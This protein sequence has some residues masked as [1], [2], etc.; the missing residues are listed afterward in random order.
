M[1]NDSEDGNKLLK[2][3]DGCRTF[4]TYELMTHSYNRLYPQPTIYTST[5]S[6]PLATPIPTSSDPPS[7]P[8]DY[9]NQNYTNQETNDHSDNHNSSNVDDN[10]S[11]LKPY[12]R[13]K[14]KRSH[15]S[16][17]ALPLYPWYD[18]IAVEHLTS[19]GPLCPTPAPKAEI[20]SNR[21]PKTSHVTTAT[22]QS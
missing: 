17:P 12:T 14:Q 10:N 15:Q 21:S 11:S 13:R 19:V 8:T 20:D 18:V 6:L 4:K 1:G 22:D 16:N 2:E 9:K 7:G 5:A 3:Q